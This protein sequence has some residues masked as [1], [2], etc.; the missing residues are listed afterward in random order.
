M[1]VR[2][3]VENGKNPQTIQLRG[4]ESVIGR[5]K[6]CAVRIPSEGVSRHHCRLTFADDILTVEDLES[7][8]GTYLN[9]QRIQEPRAV[10]P[11][12][13]L[14]VGPVIFVVKYQ[15]TPAAINRLLQADP[16][17]TEMDV[18]EIPDTEELDVEAIEEDTALVELPPSKK[19]KGGKARRERKTVDVDVIAS[20][21]IATEEEQFS[22]SDDPQ[23][24]EQA[25]E[26]PMARKP[27]A[28]AP[29]GK[30]PVAKKPAGK[31]AAKTPASARAGPE[32]QKKKPEAAGK[33]P[34][35]S[36][37]EKKPAEPEKEEEPVEGGGSVFEGPWQMPASDDIRNI[38][39]NLDEE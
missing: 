22:I 18:E 21:P 24:R 30:A 36:K 28:K 4:V 32:T 23:P 16:E 35:P 20:E 7:A 27:A 17:L 6:G 26:E 13:R 25:L 2:L 39:S 9:G 33:K 10:R 34:E 31:P 19:G 15:L 8:N 1:N 37:P 11:G 38:L 14:E 12:D 3:L 29:A 5:Q